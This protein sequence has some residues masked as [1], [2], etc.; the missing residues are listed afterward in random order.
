MEDVLAGGARAVTLSSEDAGAAARPDRRLLARA[1]REELDALF[2]QLPVPDAG[3]ADLRGALRG[4]LLA[5]P[6]SEWISPP[7]RA[8]FHAL[9]ASPANLWRGKAFGPGGGA[10][11]WGVARGQIALGRFGVSRAAGID[12]CG[13]VLRLSY[14]VPGNPRALRGIVGELRRLGP[15]SFLGRMHR[16]TR[17]GPRRI[18]YFVLEV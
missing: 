4:R 13:P 16:I 7:L 15:G 8:L 11:R 1:S 18:L 6:A 5:G 14:D 10:N 17:R 9:L 12:G 2:A 3:A